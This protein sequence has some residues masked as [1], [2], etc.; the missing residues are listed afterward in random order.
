M[1]L[2]GLGRKRLWLVEVL[3]QHCP[4]GTEENYENLRIFGVPAEIRNKNLPNKSLD[5]SLK[6]CLF[7]VAAVYDDDSNN[8]N[9]IYYYYY[10]F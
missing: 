1:K 8:N 5:H 10:V 9:N 4:R 6:T 2:K 7:G 3:S